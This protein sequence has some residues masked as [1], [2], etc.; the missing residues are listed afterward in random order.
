MRRIFRVFERLL[1]PGGTLTFFEY[2]WIRQLKTPFVNKSERR[3]LYRVGHL[4]G[5]FVRKHQISQANVLVNVPPATVRH[6][7]IAPAHAP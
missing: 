4:V 1:A 5:S 2:T 3:R 6:L 7:R